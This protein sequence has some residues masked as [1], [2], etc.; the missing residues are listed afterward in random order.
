MSAPYAWWDDDDDDDDEQEDEDDDIFL[1]TY[2][3][4]QHLFTI[5]CR[6]IASV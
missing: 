1:F 2:C 4:L 3:R 5:F 6:G